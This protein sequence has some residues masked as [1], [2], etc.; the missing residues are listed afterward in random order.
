MH[1]LAEGDTLRIA[2]LR[3]RFGLTSARRNVL[4]AGGIGITPLLSM[5]QGLDATGGDYHLHYYARSRSEAAFLADLENHQWVTLHFDDEPPE[6]RLDLGRDL[7]DPAPGTAVY[8]CGPGGFMDYA[9]GQA[10][11]LGWP[12]SALHKERFSASPAVVAEPGGGR[13]GRIH[14]APVLH[15]SAI[16][17][18]RGPERPAGERR[19]CAQLVRTEHLR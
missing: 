12:A 6:Q 19:R 16:P 4:L 9:L 17:R 13:R 10:A 3:N 18:P 5:A 2:A 15:G 14:R 1:A 7:G 11:E 8:V